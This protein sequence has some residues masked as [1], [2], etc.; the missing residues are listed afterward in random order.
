MLIGMGYIAGEPLVAAAENI[1]YTM[2]WR[3]LF[4]NRVGL[5]LYGCYVLLILCQIMTAEP[6]NIKAI[7]ATEFNSFEKGSEFRMMMEPLLGTGV[8]AADGKMSLSLICT[9]TD[10]SRR[11]HVEVSYPVILLTSG[12]LSSSVA[13]LD[14]TGR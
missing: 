10:V 11:Q 5:Y 3:F 4:Q 14:S 12:T 1:G 6:D 7:L 2:T 13:S 8:F 9:A